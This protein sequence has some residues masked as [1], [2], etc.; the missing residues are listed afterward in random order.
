MLKIR[1]KFENYSESGRNRLQSMDRPGVGRNFLN[2]GFSCPFR[3]VWHLYFK[4]LKFNRK[5][6]NELQKTK[7]TKKF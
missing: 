7:Q 6:I 2:T 4:L 1:E 3:E 5:L